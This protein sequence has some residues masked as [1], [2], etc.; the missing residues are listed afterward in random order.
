MKFY[1]A[2]IKISLALTLLFSS[3]ALLAEQS[4]YLVRHAEKVKDG[5]KD[6][7]LTE[8][9]VLRANKLA[10]RLSSSKIKHVFSTDYNRTRSTALPLANKLGLKVEIYNPRELQVFAEQVKHLKGDVL[11]VGHSNTTPVL[12]GLLGGDAHGDIDESEY[13][14]LYHLKVDNNN[15]QTILERSEPKAKRISVSAIPFDKKRFSFSSLKYQ[16]SYGGKVVGSA[17]HEL[18][19][20]R[21]SL[22]VKEKTKIDAMKIDAEL[23]VMV[24]AEDFSTKQMSMSGSMGELV[25]INLHWHDNNVSGVSQ[26]ARVS[27]KKQGAIKVEKTLPENTYS[28]SSVL[29]MAHLLTPQPNKTYAFNWYNS[30]DDALSYIELTYLGEDKITVPAGEFNVDKIQLLGGAPSQVFYVSK[31]PEPKV[32]KIEVIATPWVYEL[33]ESK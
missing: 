4:I 16:M 31:E 8:K 10:E 5:G 25:D 7:V 27:Y 9:G 21:V 2:I 11:I 14:R 3:T 26:M 28:R 22:M 18:S 6:P 23:N 29:L 24:S 30:Y 32:V 19:Q 1:Y 13:D 17:T 15:V 12:V 20:N 33:M